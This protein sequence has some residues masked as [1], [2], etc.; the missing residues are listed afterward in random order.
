[1]AVTAH[2]NRSK[3][4]KEP[5]DYMP[6]RK[7]FRCTYLAWWVAVKWR[8]H[9]KVNRTERT[10][11]HNHLAACGW[12]KVTKPSRPR[13]GRSG[14]GGGGGSTGGAG[15]TAIYFD[16]PGAD[17][18]SNAS[19]N[20]EW[21]RIKNTTSTRKTLTGWTL[22]DAS[23]HSYTFPTF[24]LAG[25]ASAKVHTGSGSDTASNLY[26]GLGTYVW[27]NT[28]DTATLRNGSGTRVDSCSYTS[29]DDPEKIC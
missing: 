14:G 28:G 6:P 22:K 17:T 16:S 26:W 9:L 11:L 3:G 18:G 25:G 1:M 27:N 23:S 10:F 13:I 5:Q 12:P 19:L 20:A 24:S 2:A 8:W 7:R 15:I 21:V 4:E 29:S